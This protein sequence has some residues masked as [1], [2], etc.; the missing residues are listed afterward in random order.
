[1]RIIGWG[2]AMPERVVTNEDLAATLDTS[3][4]WI[5]NR[6]GIRSR[7]W[8]GS[9]SGLAAEAA[10]KAID[11]AGTDPSTIDLTIVATCS[12][13]MAVPATAVEV[14]HEL[15]LSG[16]AVDVNVACSGFVHGLI[17]AAALLDG[18]MDRIVVAGAETLSRLLDQSDRD[19]AVLF[20]D[21]AGAVVVEAG[22]GTD[23][24][25]LL[26]SDQGNDPDARHLIRSPIGG[27]L[28]ME[29]RETFR[30]AVRVLVDSIERTLAS[31]SF[32]ADDVDLVVPHQANLRIIDAAAKC[33]SIPAERWVSIVADTGNTSAASVPMALAG[34]ADAGRL[35]DGDLLLLAGF[36]AG[37]SWAT[38]LI[39]WDTGATA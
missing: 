13:D 9:T 20:A 18:P 37:M 32:T 7:R 26:A 8:G 39:R 33:T 25:A 2:A 10:G 27:P 6:T 3:D 24:G 34:A 36:G 5:S 14:Q 38:A 22:S 30:R 11:R 15:G 31:T 35:H 4:E 1:M 21:G 16:A 29:G 23:G 28:A 19:T 12:P 17:T